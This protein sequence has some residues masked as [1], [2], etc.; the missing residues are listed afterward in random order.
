MVVFWTILLPESLEQSFLRY[1]I[2]QYST[3]RC[4]SWKGD[5]IPVRGGGGGFRA[6]LYNI[7]NYIQIGKAFNHSFAFST[8]LVSV[9]SPWFTAQL[10]RSTAMKSF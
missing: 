10:C 7:I 5:H 4:V 3:L 9:A 2:L 1:F 8:L 6:F